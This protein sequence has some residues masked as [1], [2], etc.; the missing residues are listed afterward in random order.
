M[1]T[2]AQV[3]S[4]LDDIVAW[5]RQ[6]ESAAGYFAALYR[7]VTAKVAAGI[8]EG[9]F[10]DGPRMERLDV[11]FANRY[12]DAFEGFT[13]RAPI[14]KS[15]TVAFA[16]TER[17][18]PIVLQHLLGG[19]NAHINLDLGIAAATIS[20]GEDLSSLHGDFLKINE[21][22]SS[23]LQRTKDSLTSIWPPLRVLDWLSG[24][25]EDTFVN[26]SMSVARDGAWQFAQA[27]SALPEDQH[28]RAIAQR[29]AIIGG[30]I[31]ELIYKP[32]PVLSAAALAVRLA[33]RGS[34]ARKIDALN[35]GH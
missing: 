25:A 29:D 30:R 18:A 35:S 34:V 24:T 26:F 12:L 11:V 10:E 17:F 33:E 22:L 13:N 27:L 8:E 15:W 3:L 4:R 5:S 14:T 20:Q 1:N 9:F 7:L 16:Q 32:G 6:S 31:A 28:A 2:I 21:V 23:L 19:M